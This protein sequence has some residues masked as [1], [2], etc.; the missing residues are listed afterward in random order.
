MNL[1]HGDSAMAI[2][3][4]PTNRAWYSDPEENF[5]SID[6]MDYCET[7]FGLKFDAPE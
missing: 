6:F 5:K 2:F 1:Y 3:T 4:G 7:N